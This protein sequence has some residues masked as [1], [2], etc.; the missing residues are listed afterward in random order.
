[1]GALSF[2]TD[3]LASL[4]STFAS[5]Q[6]GLARAGSEKLEIHLDDN[7]HRIFT[8][9]S[10]GMKM[11][12]QHGSRNPCNVNHIAAHNLKLLHTNLKANS[13]YRLSLKNIKTNAEI[14][15]HWAWMPVIENSIIHAGILYLPMGSSVSP[16]QRGANLTVRGDQL[17][18]PFAQFD[19]LTRHRQLYLSL[20]GNT[21]IKMHTNIASTQVLLKSGEAYAKP[22]INSE[23]KHISAIDSSCLVLS[24]HLPV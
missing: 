19:T 4:S 18:T 15:P 24:V 2:A 20:A 17:H 13:S 11:L 3:T 10:T 22:D 7:A 12:Y 21:N 14:N 1:M 8:E 23:V 9:F 6:N 5:R 16:N